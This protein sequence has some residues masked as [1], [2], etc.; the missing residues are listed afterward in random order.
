MY[1]ILKNWKKRRTRPGYELGKS[2]LMSSLIMHQLALG[3]TTLGP[4]GSFF[5]KFKPQ[6]LEKKK[7]MYRLTQP[8]IQLLWCLLYIYI[9]IYIWR[10]RTRLIS[11]FEMSIH[12]QFFLISHF[13]TSTFKRKVQ[14][15]DSSLL[16]K[17]RDSSKAY[18]K[19]CNEWMLNIILS[20]GLSLGMTLC[21]YKQ[22]SFFNVK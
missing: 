11:Q 7:M 3:P 9:Y 4:S 13:N 1:Y 18:L 17:E 14:L 8:R 21:T 15:N 20:I 22:N 10:V 16:M 12:A 19:R 6:I 5:F 2:G